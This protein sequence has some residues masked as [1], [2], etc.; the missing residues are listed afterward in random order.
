MAFVYAFRGAVDEAD[1]WGESATR[2]SPAD[3]LLPLLFMARAMSR[4]VIEDYQGAMDLSNQALAVAP[5]AQP[6]WRMQAATLEIMGNHEKAAEAVK[7][8]L[9]LGPVTME[10]ARRELTP[11][12]DPEAW[13]LYLDALS[14]A[15]VPDGI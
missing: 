6:A 14:R 5:D 2:L 12:Q 15:G 13:A 4:F 7:H 10:W 9:A 1:K 11:T 8:L 3:P